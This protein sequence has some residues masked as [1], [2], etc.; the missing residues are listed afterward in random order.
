MPFQDWL[1]ELTERNDYENWAPSVLP[2]TQYLLSDVEYT[3]VPWDF[4]MIGHLFKVKF[5]HKNQ[6]QIET[7]MP[8]DL[9]IRNTL[10]IIYGV[11]YT[12]WN[13]V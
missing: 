10:E 2:Q 7:V 3:F 12:L 11:D 6:Q 9:D 5:D 1:L 4:E 8:E 13:E